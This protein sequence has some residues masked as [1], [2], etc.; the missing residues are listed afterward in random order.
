MVI[1]DTPYGNTTGVPFTD[2]FAAGVVVSK[3]GSFE[4]KNI[5]TL[6]NIV[7]DRLEWQGFLF[8]DSGAAP[9][10]NRRLTTNDNKRYPAEWVIYDANLLDVFRPMLGFE[11][12][13]DVVCGTSNHILCQGK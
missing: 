4:S 1:Q 5:D 11:R 12:T 2:Q 10:L 3:G 8:D 9:K 7:L 6:N 13:V